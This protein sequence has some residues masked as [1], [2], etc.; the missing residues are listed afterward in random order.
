MSEPRVTFEQ[1]KAD[2]ERALPRNFDTDVSPTLISKLRA[3]FETATPLSPRGVSLP[4]SE[5]VRRNAEE[6]AA[7]FDDE[8]AGD[9]GLDRI[10][11]GEIDYERVLENLNGRIIPDKAAQEI[12]DRRALQDAN[13]IAIAKA[14]EA[15]PA[16]PAFGARCA[17]CRLMLRPPA[18]FHYGDKWDGRCTV[19]G[20]FSGEVLPLPPVKR[21]SFMPSI[22]A[23]QRS[24]MLRDVETF[25]A[26]RPTTSRMFTLTNGPR[27]PIRP[28][29]LREEIKGFHRWLSKMAA[30]PDFKAF[31]LRMQWRATEFGEPKWDDE[32]GQMT[33]HLHAHVLVTEPRGISK[34]RRG[35]MRRK[36]W[37][38]FGVHWDDGGQI[39]NA[40]EFVKYPVKDSDIQTIMQKG[41]PG[42]L[43]DFYDAVRGLH[44]VQPMGD[45][46]SARA[47]RRAKAR[48]IQ[49][50]TGPDGRYLEEMTD[51]N[52]QKRPFSGPN[53]NRERYRMKALWATLKSVICAR[54]RLPGEKAVESY[55]DA[56]ETANNRPET[57]KERAKP[58]LSNR[59]IARL[60]PAPYGG[61]IMEPAVV[62]WGYD[63][64]RLAVFNQPLVKRIRERHRAAYADAV[65]ARDLTRE[66][67]CADTHA[68]LARAQR[69]AREGSQR[70]NNCPGEFRPPRPSLADLALADVENDRN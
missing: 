22:A 32:T 39:E 7:L 14:L 42:C 67:A 40:R 57:A 4:K 45:L 52:A 49:A 35:K 33:L 55:E 66:L 12:R 16:A 38:V 60:A 58:R 31:G 53:K 24:K 15:R 18:Q 47:A 19:I 34:K 51:W 63:G 17:D 5:G 29:T 68:P 11:Q 6:V 3:G 64:N 28:I 44:I 27:V 56:E 36:L 65:A 61:S 1:A 50:L 62:V 54:Y 48:R 70:S 20:L 37:K 26:E 8:G 41:G 13:T 43:A 21:V 2:F 69:A 9:D 10:Y 25:L 46:K 59:I 30:N 23:G